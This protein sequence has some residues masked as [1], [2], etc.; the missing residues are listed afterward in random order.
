MNDHHNSTWSHCQMPA[1]SISWAMMICWRS[2]A[3]QTTR[4]SSRLTSRS[5]SLASTASPSMRTRL[6]ASIRSRG[7]SCRFH[8]QCRYARSESGH[9]VP[10][11]S[12]TGA[13]TP[14]AT[15]AACTHSGH[16]HRGNWLTAARGGVGVC[17]GRGMARRRHVQHAWRTPGARPC[18]ARPGHHLRLGQPALTGAWPRR[19]AQLHQGAALL[20]S[21]LSCIS[22]DQEGDN[23]IT[24]YRGRSQM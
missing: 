7:R 21:T 14:C 11:K 22:R 24:H 10:G 4:R 6:R 18:S 23:A 17:S 13:S 1:G 3:S 9:L 15:A 2:S 5:S 12:P 8:H 19:G 16:K 20:Q